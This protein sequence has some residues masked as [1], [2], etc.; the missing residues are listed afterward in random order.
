M[1]KGI[2]GAVVEQAVWSIDTSYVTATMSRRH[3][4]LGV[5]WWSLRLE[6]QKH[7]GCWLQSHVGNFR[8]SG[9]VLQTAS[10]SMVI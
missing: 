10:D 7:V 4:A 1:R 3:I 6:D 5:Q 8:G 2:G 9:V